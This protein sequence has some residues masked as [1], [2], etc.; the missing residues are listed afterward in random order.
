MK[1]INLLWFLLLIF[2][3]NITAQEMSTKGYIYSSVV[4]NNNEPVIYNS[5]NLNTYELLTTN[6][7]VSKEDNLQ[8]IVF[9]PLKLI[10]YS[11]VGFLRETRINIAQKNGISTLGFGM[12]FDNSS[13]YSKR[14]NKKIATAFKDF[15]ALRVQGKEEK[16]YEYEIV[17]HKYYYSMDSIYAETYKSLLS[18]S[19]KITAGYNISLFEIIGGDKIDAD[20]DNIVDNYYVVESNNYSLGMTYVFS[21][22][23]ALSVTL[24]HSLK[25]GS[26]KEDEKRVGFIGYSFSYAQRV[27]ILNKQFEKTQEYLK[28][29]FIPS[30][31]GGLSIEFQNATR[32]KDY[33]K[34]GITQTIVY[35]PFVEFKINP[36]NQ[37]RI[38]IP[39]KKYSG[40]T[41]ETALGPF[42][43][44]TL[45][46]VKVD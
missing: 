38:G 14:G 7:Q 27:C 19:I 45:Q 16:D 46:I 31:V 44:W 11:K 28:T 3:A 5:V 36:K 29:L 33:A 9:A 22:K 37:F 42:I 34:K 13:P 12:G 4:G 26:Q 10:D 18:N 41:D 24:H 25:R 1:Y 20:N 30:V 40:E 39:I 32:N 17:K 21:L 35:T 23:R 2:S 8:K 6:I 15:P 43:Q